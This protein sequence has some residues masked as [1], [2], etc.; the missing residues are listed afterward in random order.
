M[1]DDRDELLFNRALL[2]WALKQLE[3]LSDVERIYKAKEIVG[4]DNVKTL[5]EKLYDWEMS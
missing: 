5:L 3:P 4:S 1:I 2:G